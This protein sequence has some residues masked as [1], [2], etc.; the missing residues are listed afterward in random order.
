[1]GMILGLYWGY[2]GTYMD[3]IRVVLGLCLGFYRDCTRV[4]L[5]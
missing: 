1:M 2:I 3:C 5:G 4:E